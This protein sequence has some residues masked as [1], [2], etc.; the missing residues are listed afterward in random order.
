M[1]NLYVAV[2]YVIA[3]A[4]AGVWAGDPPA[5]S[6]APA[7]GTAPGTS[8]AP[9][10][11]PGITGEASPTGELLR[12][13]DSEGTAAGNMGD[14]YDNRDRGHSMLGLKPY[15]QVQLHPYTP[16]ERKTNSDWA[17]QPIV[18]PKVVFGNSST[19]AAPP[20]GGS[21]PRTLYASPGGLRLGYAQYRRNNIYMYPAH[22]DFTAGRNGF[23]G[24]Y[25]GDLYPTNSP[26]LIISLGSSGSDQPFMKAIPFTL[27]AFRPD[28][29][30]KL[31]ADGLLM[32][33]LQMIL[34][35]SSKQVKEPA[36][37]LTGKAHPPVFNGGDV[38]ALKMVKMAH[39]ME[40]GA[41][42]PEVEL[43]VV[44]EDTAQPGRDYCDPYSEEIG[45]TPGVIARVF[46]ATTA[47]RRM[48][49]S[50]VET[51]DPNGRP[52][53]F[54]WVVL[55][56]DPAKVTIK[57]QNEG[58]S[59]AEITIG[60]HDRGPSASVKDIASNRV[61]IG[62]FAHNGAYYSAPAFVTSFTLDSEGRT[63]DAG[64]RLLEIGYGMCDSFIGVSD[65]R[66]LVST[67]AAEPAKGAVKLL[68]A[69]LNEAQLQALRQLNEK[70]GVAATVLA[71][72]EKR[73]TAAEE[74][75]KKATG[76]K[77]PE[78]EAAL[79]KVKD[80][81]GEAMKARD[82]IL[83]IKGEG[84]PAGVRE[85]I[86]ATLQAMIADA[87]FYGENFALFTPLPAKA[88]AVRKELIA[89]GIVDGK[90][91]RP[92]ELL[93]LLGG[94]KP[95][96]ERLSRYQQAQ[97]ARFAGEL[98]AASIPGVLYEGRAN[99]VD[100]RLSIPKKFRDV[101]H[102]AADGT[103]MGYTRYDGAKATEFNRDGAII[104]ERDGAGRCIKAQMVQYERKVPPN[105][106]G[107]AELE[108]PLTFAPGRKIIE[109][110]YAGAGDFV[111]T[112]SESANIPATTSPAGK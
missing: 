66:T 29:K 96:R 69:K 40:V 12:K 52:L 82:K 21:N 33:T 49:V 61:D 77:K 5:A 7:T 63:Y 3:A 95:A 112:A 102:Y 42:P 103:R 24:G 70:Y 57:P 100:F 34:R 20:Q 79:K 64:G 107:L 74:E 6:S 35:A 37:Y 43:K 101:Y 84:L 11:R 25:Y 13:W 68:T 48:V 18:L 36:D 90:S 22:H 87:G 31:V 56:G 99:L 10:T 88:E 59:V 1:K 44:E 30:A 46:R 4:V 76:E 41:I 27:A 26:Y 58:G 38:D 60:Y 65:W 55:Q 47:T 72:V 75:A 86:V 16:E 92:L 110:K 8:T 91:N 14:W 81:A 98:L 71:E 94:D 105:V 109:Y 32:P 39:E 50:A 62:V 45:D 89:Y 9:A 106:K 85:P 67:L 93:P 104:L 80:E 17:L 54:E 111:G 97:V 15:P 53:K 73:Q 28:V 108:L 23:N 78:A 2:G 51:K 83:T 19:A